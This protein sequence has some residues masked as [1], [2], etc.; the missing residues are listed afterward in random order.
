MIFLRGD[1]HG[2]QRSITDDTVDAPKEELTQLSEKVVDVAEDEGA[3][4]EDVVENVEVAKKKKASP[5]PKRKYPK[6]N[7]K[8]TT[9]SVQESN[10]DD[11]VISIKDITK[12]PMI[13][14]MTSLLQYL[15][16]ER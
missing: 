6:R 13:K 15:A 1:E 16:D 12:N 3:K 11:K 5:L 2:T 14:E 10:E 9:T 8:S 7:A 4:E